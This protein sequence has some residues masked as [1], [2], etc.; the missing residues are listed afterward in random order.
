MGG[1]PSE[2][3]K[4]TAQRLNDHMRECGEKYQA[5]HNDISEFRDDINNAL[6]V[7]S[8]RMWGAAVGS[9]SILLLIA[10]TLLWAVVSP[11][12]GK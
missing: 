12:I 11:L 1:E 6:R 9:I 3:A 10:G 4:I 5:L 7:L 8:G 2:I